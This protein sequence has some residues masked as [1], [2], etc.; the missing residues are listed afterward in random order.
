[1]I[2]QLNPRERIFIISGGVIIGLILL[3][4]V[5]LAP[6]Q[7]TLARLDNQ[8]EGRSAQL[9]QVSALQ[10]EY[11][12]LQQKTVQIERRLE[13]RRDFSTLTFVENLAVNTA[14]RE[15]L[16]SM[17]PQ[18]PVTRDQFILDSVELKLERLT[19]RQVLEL[20]WGVES[21]EVPMQISN[22]FLKRRFDEKSLLD[23]TMT[24]TAMRRAS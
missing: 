20:L 1:M 2:S 12:S 15:N 13:N 5:L 11:L 19:L 16:V 7:T 3:Y 6:Y 24:V 4:F 22:L 10:A 21:A 18:A 17:R 9:Q 23:A 8:I 14:G